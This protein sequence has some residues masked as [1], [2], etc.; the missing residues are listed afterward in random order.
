MCYSTLANLKFWRADARHASWLF[1]QSGA[2]KQRL[3][4]A[5]QETTLPW[6]MDKNFSNHQKEYLI[7]YEGILQSVIL[8][9]LPTTFGSNEAQAQWMRQQGCL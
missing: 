6:S 9:A 3:A 8:L 7:E 1:I 4:W 2:K 5:S